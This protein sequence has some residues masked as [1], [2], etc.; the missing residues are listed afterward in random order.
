MGCLGEDDDFS[1]FRTK[2][3]ELI[4]V[5]VCLTFIFHI[6]IIYQ[7]YTDSD[8]VYRSGLCICCGEQLCLSSDVCPAS[9]G[10]ILKKMDC[11][12]RFLDFY[13]TL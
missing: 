5:T 2:V 4:K 12:K 1:E 13:I 3:S 11:K 7:L 9:P 10:R 6:T 8:V